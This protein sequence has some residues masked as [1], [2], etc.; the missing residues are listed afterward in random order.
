MNTLIVYGTK[1]GCTEKCADMLAKKLEGKADIQNLKNMKDI[2]LSQ[3][4]SII[5]GGSIYIGRIQKEVSDFCTNNIEALK[6]KKLGLFICGMQE[7]ELQTELNTAFPKELLSAAVVK[8]CFGGQFILKN[9]SFMDKMVVK[10]V[11]KTDKDIS[12]ISEAAIDSFAKQMNAASQQ[13]ADVR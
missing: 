5:V 11:A 8:E 12:N 7:K 2:D 6:N 3:Y 1:Y 4:D 9:M 10:M 13:V